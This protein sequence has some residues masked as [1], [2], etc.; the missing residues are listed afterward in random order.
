MELKLSGANCDLQGAIVEINPIR[1]AINI[2]VCCTWRGFN[3]GN[4]CCCLLVWFVSISQMKLDWNLMVL[5][6]ITPVLWQL[7]L[8]PDGVASGGGV[9]AIVKKYCGGF[10]RTGGG[11]PLHWWTILGQFLA[12]QF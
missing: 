8:M 9:P 2:Q 7:D 3:G 6:G 1:T 4:W 12:G 5:V 10:A 11:G